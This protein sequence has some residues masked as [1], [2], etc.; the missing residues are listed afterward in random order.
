MRIAAANPS[1]GVLKT[2]VNRPWVVSYDDVPAIRKLYV[3][4]RPRKYRIA[5]SASERY[6][7][8]EVAFFS[9]ALEVPRAADPTRVSV[10]DIESYIARV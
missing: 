2:K 9:K 7:G 6:Q 4:Y 8:G 10:R 3:G 1:H 5:Y